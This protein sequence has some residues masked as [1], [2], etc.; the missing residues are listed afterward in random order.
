MPRLCPPSSG[1]LTSPSFPFTREELDDLSKPKVLI[2]GGGIGGLTLAILL[3]K[4][5][6]PF[7]VL[8]RA[9]EIKPLGSAIA[10][11]SAVAP[12]FVQMGFLTSSSNVTNT[13][14]MSTC[15]EDLTPCSV[16][17]GEY[18]ISKPDLYDLLFHSI[19]RDSIHLGKRVR[20]FAQNENGV[21]VRCS[22]NSSYHIIQWIT[23]TT[24]QNTVC[25]MVIHFLD[26]KS[27]KRN[28]SCRNSETPRGQMSKVMLEEI[29]LDTWHDGR[30]VLLGDALLALLAPSQRSMMPRPL[31]TGSPPL[32]QASAEDLEKVFKEYRA[33]RYP[34]AKEAFEASHV[35]IKNLGKPS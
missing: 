27:F 4:A 14:L 3:H 32:R 31:R 12:Q 9:K 24:K 26:K 15:S 28:D 11:G 16:G 21:L 18:V 7:L 23:F 30:T 22:D 29:V 2:S 5:N 13:T 1:P 8:E 19:L 17:Y 33:E 34:V 10:L 25:W 20:P 35:F 6:T